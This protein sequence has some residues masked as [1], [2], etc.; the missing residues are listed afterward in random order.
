[1]KDGASVSAPWWRDPAP[2]WAYRA[3]ARFPGPLAARLIL[4][5]RARRGKESPTRLGER[6]GVPSAPRPPGELIWL[7]AASVGES[8]SLLPL[9]EA[10]AR[11]R[12]DLTP[13]VTTSTV[14]SA[15]IMRQRLAAPATHQFLPVDTRSAVRRFLGHWRPSFFGMVESELWPTLLFETEAAGVPRALISARISEASAKSWAR[16]PRTIAALL[17]RLDLMLAQTP[18]VRER[19]IR[20]G[21][22]PDRVRVTGSLKDAAEPP[23]ADPE[24]LAAAHAALGDRPRWLVASTH[25]G[26][27]APALDAHLR[28][29]A[30]RPDFLTLLAPRHPER[31]EEIAERI[32][33]RDLSFGR[34]SLDDAPQPSHQVFLIDRLGELGVWYRLVDIVL[35]GGGFAPVGGHNP[36]EAARLSAAILS[37]A[38]TPN[39]QAAYDRLAEA[40]AVRLLDAPEAIGGALEA[41][42][43]PDGRPNADAQAMAIRASAASAPD[44]R[45]IEVTLDA[46]RPLFPV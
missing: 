29:A 12:P 19:L 32:R 39:S 45:V 33:E 20:L 5:R 41:L 34:A 21:A 10:L 31:A 22:A 8:L 27:D 3:A 6:F 26:E 1:M 28:V 40:D 23:P 38:R 15:E 42:L 46:L 13:L 14:T 25:P 43:T 18:E 30:A 44:Q 35:M 2:L 9:L 4:A 11:K 17:G 37:G 24:R 16:A 36:L 7:H